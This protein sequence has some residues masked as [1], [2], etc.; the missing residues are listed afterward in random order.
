MVNFRC[1]LC[2]MLRRQS[3]I[4]C[5]GEKNIKYHKPFAC[6][7]STISSRK[8]IQNIRYQKQI[9]F[10]VAENIDTIEKAD[11]KEKTEFW[12]TEAFR[13]YVLIRVRLYISNVKSHS[14]ENVGSKG[15][16]VP[17]FCLFLCVRLLYSIKVLAENKC[18]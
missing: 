17:K 5:K 13:T 11:A 2:C 3:F 12:H 6:T 1:S 7:H 14:D 18:S 15:L 9:Q 8:C 10:N 16:S 4:Q